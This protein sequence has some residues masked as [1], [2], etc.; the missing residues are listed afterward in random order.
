MSG[1]HLERFFDHKKAEG[2]WYQYWEK[3]G[4]FRPADNKGAHNYCI[5]IPPP[6]VTGILH[7]GHAL[8]NTLQD[9]LIRY[10][11]MLGENVLWQPGTDHAGISTQYVVEKELAA[12]GVTKEELGREEFLERVWQWKEQKGG[13]ILNQLKRLGASCDWSRERFTMD[14]G[15]S[16]AVREVFVRLYE[17]GLIYRGE[18]MV[19]WCPRC[20]TAL[21]NLEVV[22][23]EDQQEPGNLYYIM[24]PFVEGQGGLTVA[25]TRPETMLGDTAVAINPE[26]DRYG[27]A[28]GR[29]VRLPLTDHEIPVIEDPYVDA[30]FGTGA[31][32]I[33]PGHDFNDYEIGKKHGLPAPR[34]IDRNAHMTDYV[35]EKYRGMDRYEARE[36][37]VKDLKEQGLLEKTEPYSLLAGRCYRCKTVVEPAVSTQWFVKTGPLARPAMEAVEEEKTTIIPESQNKEYM[38]WMENI[39]DWCISRQIWWGHQIP[40]WHCR[41][42]NEFTVSRIDPDRCAHCK[43]KNIEQDPD[44]LDTWFSSALWPFSTL[45]WPDK[46]PELESFY[47]NTAMVTGFDILKF[48]VARMMMMGIHIMGDVPFTHV[49][50]HGLVRDELGRKKSKTLQNFVDPLKLVEEYG[51]DALRFTLGIETYTGRDVRLG[52]HRLIESKKFIN[53]VWNASRFTLQNLEGFIPGGKAEARFSPADRWILSR[54][55]KAAREAA[56]NLEAFRFHEYADAVYHFIWDEL[57][58]W[59]IEWSKSALYNPETEAHKRG[60]QETLVTAL[61]GAL[62]LLHPLMPFVT[63]EIYQALP[64]EG[65][66]I[67]VEM[68]PQADP[69]KEDQKLEERMDVV[70]EAVIT[71]RN[72]RSENL[73]PAKARTDVTLIPDDESTRADLA[74]LAGY[75]MSP[76]QVQVK[77][78]VVADPGAE[79][80]RKAVTRR[81]GPVIVCLEVAGLVDPAEEI[82]R[83]EKQLNK[84]DS[85]LEKVLAKLENRR[86]IEKA[87]GQEVEKQRRIEAEL[88]AKRSTLVET[89]QRM[90]ALIE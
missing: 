87:P 75:I 55:Q 41:D 67:M 27:H 47:P 7:E 17:E 65:E 56:R 18:Y 37:V 28:R 63:E 33:T 20:D 79:P 38:N 77:E 29:K 51:A 53:K 3:K 48:W 15:L 36:A 90:Q 74:S 23:P 76:P 2:K 50:L 4:Y 85:E 19:N 71:I 49:F 60:A 25:T 64:G 52:E 42:C 5:V 22:F 24:Y 26:D 78:L 46:T 73:V 62:K 45:G 70:R 43:S 10:H 21:S 61:S 11:R 66:S 39:R 1:K 81:C 82:K 84:L 69:E 68:F 14:E 58:D 6:N 35:P 8:N 40:A 13:H 16:R 59:Y 9:V 31:L 12:E 86:F 89:R 83:I 44:V 54:L 88:K 30:E 72:L 32:K 34:A 80:E 57:C